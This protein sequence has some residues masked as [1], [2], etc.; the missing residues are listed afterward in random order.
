MARRINSNLAIQK[1]FWDIETACASDQVIVDYKKIAKK[2]IKDWSNGYD[3]LATQLGEFSLTKLCDYL[4]KT[5]NKL[6]D[7]TNVPSEIQ[8]VYDELANLYYK[9][10]AALYRQKYEEIGKKIIQLLGTE[11]NRRR[12]VN[13]LKKR[14]QN[15]LRQLD[16]RLLSDFEEVSRTTNKSFV[17]S[18]K[19]FS[20][21]PIAD[22]IFKNLKKFGEKGAAN[23]F[24]SDYEALLAL[25]AIKLKLSEK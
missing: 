16:A 9:K 12:Q 1:S 10:E 13:D 4:Y 8:V 23:K 24:R 7:W 3:F 17:I 14:A 11:I 15:I 5:S 18:F 25:Q 19:S 6:V 2:A 20:L 22:E 21:S